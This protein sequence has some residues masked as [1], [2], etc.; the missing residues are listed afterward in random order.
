MCNRYGVHVCIYKLQRKSV[1]LKIINL[2][3]IKISY[4]IYILETPSETH[5]WEEIIFVRMD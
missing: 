2:C 3:K 1:I 5:E 4:M